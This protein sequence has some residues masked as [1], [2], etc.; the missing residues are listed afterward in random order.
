M[1]KQILIS[2]L[3]AFSLSFILLVI[4]AKTDNNIP[5]EDAV[6][7]IIEYQRQIDQYVNELGGKY[8]YGQASQNNLKQAMD[9]QGV[10]WAQKYINTWAN[11]G[12]YL[13]LVNAK[14]FFYNPHKEKL[15]LSIEVINE[16]GFA[17]P[18]QMKY[19]SDG[20]AKLYEM[21]LDIGKMLQEI[22]QNMATDGT[23]ADQINNANNIIQT[24][25][26]NN[27]PQ[28]VE[29]GNQLKQEIQTKQKEFNVLSDS[30]VSNYQSFTKTEVF[31]VLGEEEEEEFVD[32]ILYPAE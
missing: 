29:N 25:H 22:T 19:L 15:R 10:S 21:H 20:M 6:N 23:Y 4:P 1:R 14:D 7:K 24:G 18:D 3:L 31:S 8:E 17:T 27:K 13:R 9:Q 26:S 12:L 28:Q 11:N 30:T 2:I 16:Q 5:Q 32:V